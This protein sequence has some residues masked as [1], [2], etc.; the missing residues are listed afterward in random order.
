MSSVT[1]AVDL[2]KHVF[3]VAVSA[4]QG[5]IT[6][7]RRMSRTQ[8]ERFWSGRAPCRVVM[9]ACA[10][11]HY[12]GRRLR[13]LGFEIRLLP[14]HYVRA[15][16]RRNKTDR[17]D[18]EALLE[19]QRCGGILPVSIKSEDQQAIASLHAARSQ[20]MSTRTAR[21]NALRALLHEYGICSPAGATRL[22]QRLPEILEQQRAVLP[23]R[24][25]LVLRGYAE[26]VSHLEQ[27]TRELEKEL[28]QVA[29]QT[30]VISTLQQVPGVGVLSATALYA[31]VGDIHTFRSGRHLASWMGLTPREHSSGARRRLGRISKQGNP[32]L[33]TLLIH[34][35]R[36]ALLAAE[37]KKKAGKALSHLEQWAL[38]LCAKKPHNQA[39]VALANKM[40]RV[41]WALWRYDR[42]FEMQPAQRAA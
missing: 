36:S 25:L 1:I 12:W 35:A 5:R 32:Y 7:R 6:E 28:D 27:R 8:F 24:V 37:R 40:A 4:E 41:I 31:S 39:A 16:V 30:P 3:E 22:L 13:A 10:S 42:A 9:E 2:A 20:W 29:R 14:P 21:I 26:E 17:T 11:A 34:G 38:E 33:R 19:A 18:C 23:S 15:Y